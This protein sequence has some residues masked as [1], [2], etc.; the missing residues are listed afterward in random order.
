MEGAEEGIGIRIS[1]DLGIRGGKDGEE[2]GRDLLVL[3]ETI[4]GAVHLRDGLDSL[5]AFG[6]AS[7][8]AHAP[9]PF[10]FP[11]PFF[12][13]VSCIRDGGGVAGLSLS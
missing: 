7:Q 11:S 3:Q 4:G 8:N 9:L 13:L 10:P 5:T 1:R 12:S 6:L 2:E